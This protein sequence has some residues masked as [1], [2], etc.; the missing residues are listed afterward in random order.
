MRADELGV[1]VRRLT[2]AL[3]AS[4]PRCAAGFPL[5]SLTRNHA[6]TCALLFAATGPLDVSAQNEG[7]HTMKLN[8]A[9]TWRTSS[10]AIL[11]SIYLGLDPVSS[12]SHR[13]FIRI[14]FP[15]QIIDLVSHGDSA[16]LGTLTQETTEYRSVKA[17][18]GDDSQPFQRIYQR[19]PIDTTTA[20]ALA[21][22][23]LQSGQDTLATD[24]LVP[25]WAHRITDC[26]SMM[27]WFKIGE[28][29]VEQ[30]FYCVHGQNDSLP[31]KRI[32][33]SNYD[34][35]TQALHL[36][37]RYD[38]FTSSLPGGTYSRDG[39]VMM[40]KPK[41]KKPKTTRQRTR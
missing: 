14:S 4:S 15:G 6:L 24:S 34:R 19:E 31:E 23:L 2:V 10:Q 20:T 3:S 28:R 1:P 11:D 5:Q 30:D 41:T 26:W 17:E 9:Y 35:I 38:A 32:L 13:T 40:W 27:Y 36:K 12:T 29:Y 37:E 33:I 39:F 21:S 18:W 8:E 25:G 7:L 16:F 22:Q